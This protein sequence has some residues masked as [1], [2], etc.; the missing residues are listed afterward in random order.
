MKLT[1]KVVLIAII[2]SLLLLSCGINPFVVIIRTDQAGETAIFVLSNSVENGSSGFSYNTFTAGVTAASGEIVEF[3]FTGAA[4]SM[5]R[6]SSLGCSSIPSPMT[7][8][9]LIPTFAARR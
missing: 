1:L 3:E 9:V 8:A 7:R 5:R 4:S 2:T 6:R